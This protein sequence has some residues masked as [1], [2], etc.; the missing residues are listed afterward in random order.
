[1]EEK[2]QA[3]ALTTPG[4]R[5]LCSAFTPP[6]GASSVLSCSTVSSLRSPGL[7]APRWPLGSGHPVSTTPQTVQPSVASN[8]PPPSVGNMVGEEHVLSLQTL[9][10]HPRQA[11][12]N[13]YPPPACPLP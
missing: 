8:H 5:A 11:R 9:R 7:L 1:M 6:L 3:S 10:P 12:L 4:P 2:V 13:Q